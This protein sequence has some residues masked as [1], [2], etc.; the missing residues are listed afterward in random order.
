MSYDLMVFEPTQAPRKHTEF[1]EW[2]EQQTEWGEEHDYNDP[3]VTSPA[4]RSWYEEIIRTFPDM[5]GPDAPEDESEDEEAGLRLTE[6]S[7]GHHVIYAVFSW[8][9]AEEAYEQVKALACKHG[10]GFF[11]ASGD[12]A[13]VFLPDGSLMK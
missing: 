5:N 11:D 2:Y 6:Y 12:E 1:L 10:V 4:L 7:I 3:A 9:M 13:D 8:S